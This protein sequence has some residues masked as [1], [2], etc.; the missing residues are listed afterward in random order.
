MNLIRPIL[1]RLVGVLVA[2]LSAQAALRWGWEIPTE[3]QRE[4]VE[5]LVNLITLMLATYPLTHKL[6]NRWLNPGDAASG[7][8]GAQEKREAE[9][10]RAQHVS[11]SHFGI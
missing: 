10:L 4:F 6:V 2:W 7:T 5:H 1:G 8:L 11:N 3:A 9:A